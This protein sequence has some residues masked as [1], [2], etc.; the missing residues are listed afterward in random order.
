MRRAARFGAR[1]ALA[2]LISLG[3]Y[4]GPGHLAARRRLST[5]GGYHLDDLSW[6][7]G[8]DHTTRHGTVPSMTCPAGKYRPT[9]QTDNNYQRLV[10]LRTEGCRDC[11]RGKYGSVAGLTTDSCTAECPLGRYRDRPGGK[12]QEDCHLCPPGTYGNVQGLTTKY[13]SANCPAGKYNRHW[14]LD[15]PQNCE[16]CPEGARF[17][18]CNWEIVAQ[19][20]Q[21]VRV[22]H[23][24]LD[25]DPSLKLRDGPVQFDVQDDEGAVPR[26]PDRPLPLTNPFHLPLRNEIKGVFGEEED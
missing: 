18:Q 3:C 6:F 10:S 19:H 17:S 22:H 25:N 11:P 5:V 2:A 9:A 15:D 4:F 23:Y 16:T 26:D 21:G 8:E 7:T 14:G 12:T 1:V 20:F 24:D 13:C